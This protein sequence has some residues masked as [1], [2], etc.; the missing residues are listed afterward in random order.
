MKVRHFGGIIGYVI[1]G[2]LITLLLVQVK[3]LIE[4]HPIG[5]RA[6]ILAYEFLQGLLRSVDEN[7]LPVVVADIGQMPGGKPDQPTSREELIKVVEALSDKKPRA[8]AIDID[9]SPNE[10]GWQHIN[11]PAFF[12]FCLKTKKEKNVPIFLGIYRTQREQ[13]D[14][15]LGLEKY[16]ELASSMVILRDTSRM[17]RW[18][19]AEGVSEP[20]P[21][22][23]AVLAQSYRKTLP[24]PPKW[25]AW[26][27][28]M[29]EDS[30]SGSQVQPM[31]E[32]KDVYAMTLVNYSKLDT[33]KL[34]AQPI[35]TAAS[36][37]ESG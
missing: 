6:K 15:W 33:I 32:F 9:F 1:V 21:T 5:Y 27:L 24:E 8:I 25:L 18:I 37:I 22:L 17:P 28:E 29:I 14:T 11:D 3:D 23:S 12:D 19:Q 13:P 26:S 20:L 16:K 34:E 4:Q 36:V 2:L 7:R 30:Q 31:P 35:K 10:R